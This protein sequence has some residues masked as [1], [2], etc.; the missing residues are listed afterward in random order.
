[1]TDDRGPDESLLQMTRRS[2]RRRHHFGNAQPASDLGNRRAG[3]GLPQ[4]G[5][6]L[7]V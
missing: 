5:C 4:R 6:D 2:G 3:F 7:L 1:M